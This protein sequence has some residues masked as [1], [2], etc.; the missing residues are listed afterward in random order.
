LARYDGASVRVVQLAES[1]DLIQGFQFF[2]CDIIGPA[3]LAVLDHVTLAHNTFDGD[4]ESVLWEVP[5]TR[6]RVLGAIGIRD[7]TFQDCRFHRIG[8]AGTAE[9]VAAF[10]AGTLIAAPVDPHGV[11]PAPPAAV[12]QS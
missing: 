6:T 5:H 7:C 10:K 3:V 9:F 2:D 4:M 11:P 12:G 8:L 1:T